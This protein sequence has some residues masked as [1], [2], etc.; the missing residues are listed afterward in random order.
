M[1]AI[2]YTCGYHSQVKSGRLFDDSRLCNSTEKSSWLR[3]MQ[4]QTM[5]QPAQ[6]AT[7]R[8]AVKTQRTSNNLRV[9]SL[10]RVLRAIV[11]LV[12][13][14]EDIEAGSERRTLARKRRHH[15][16]RRDDVRGK[17]HLEGRVTEIICH[18]H[19]RLHRAKREITPPSTYPLNNG[20]GL[21]APRVTRVG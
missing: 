12:T 1:S 2:P 17:I 11:K 14:G 15:P 7:T 18:L 19:R 20:K 21:Q 8:A 16:V 13:A 4:T 5:I 10:G 9:Q 3:R 6:A